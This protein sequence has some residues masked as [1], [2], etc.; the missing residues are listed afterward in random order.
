MAYL[1]I[2]LGTTN[3]V[4]AVFDTGAVTVIRNALGGLLTP[5][6]VGARNGEYVVGAVAAERLITHPEATAAC[7]KRAMGSRA[8]YRLDEQKFSPE[9]LSGLVLKDLLASVHAHCGLTPADVVITVPAYFNNPQREATKRAAAMAGLETVRLINEPTAAAIAYGLQEKPDGARF[10]VLDLGGGTFD[11]SLMEYFDGVLEV[12]ASGG[13]SYLG[14]ED[15]TL[16]IR[17]AFLSARSLDQR[18]LSRQE[19]H[20]IHRA[21]ELAKLAIGRD[22]T[23]V[24]APG[25]EPLSLSTGELERLFSPLFKRIVT[26][27]S[28]TLRDARTSPEQ[29]A[30]IILVGGAT[31]L[32]AFRAVVAKMF[33]RIPLAH[34]DPDCVVA[35]GAAIQA[36]LLARDEA[37]E[38]VVLTD[39]SPHSLGV[40][41][42]NGPI[43]QEIGTFLP[44]IE[45][46]TVVPVSRME[47]LATRHD[48]Q[49]RIALRIFQG[50]NRQVTDNVCLGELDLEVPPG[51]AGAETIEVRFSY[52]ANGLLE[53][54][55]R[56]TSTGR[57]SSISI[58]QGGA[59]LTAEE[60]ERTR[61]RLA[62]LKF[63]PREQQVNQLVLAR[64]DRLFAEMV[65]E[66]RVALMQ[67]IAQF[68]TELA[69]QD[70]H[71]IE[72]FR[73]RMEAAL[74]ELETRL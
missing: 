56:V 49:N 41:V 34:I 14:G 24:E 39:V 68:E 35:H 9:E 28:R 54:D 58:D 69:S 44:I 53:V 12:H 74:D 38:D 67:L 52:D 71:R 10:L 8:S 65:G 57:V 45:R 30:E 46:N 1:G 66:T 63:H 40:E 62:A 42:F 19:L 36:A 37:L 16:A 26:P 33:G 5:S 17:E 13:D 60:I 2:D 21:S 55:A 18:K 59:A 43:T 48:Q 64:A 3:S 50:E 4:A 73:G 11:V 31:R 6:V 20:Q 51:P 27:V 47:I 15:F 70:E 7:F 22:G 25:R 72:R 32:Q 61:Q 23:V 29:L